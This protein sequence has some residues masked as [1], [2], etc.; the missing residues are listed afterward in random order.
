MMLSR[1]LPYPRR[2]VYYKCVALLSFPPI[3]LWSVAM[4]QLN[5]CS[6]FSR[7]G[8]IPGVGKG[9]Y[10]NFIFFSGF[11]WKPEMRLLF[12]LDLKTRTWS[13]TPVGLG[14]VRD[15]GDDIQSSC[16]H[17]CISDIRI[18]LTGA[19]RAQRKN[20]NTDGSSQPHPHTHWPKLIEATKNEEVVKFRLSPL[21]NLQK[22]N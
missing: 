18:Q 17:F 5:S 20:S 10:V 21:M 8:C 2:V 16:L 4:R 14:T 7:S 22:L 12:E 3:L 1:P 6:D 11:P 19:A 15:S 13:G 9:N